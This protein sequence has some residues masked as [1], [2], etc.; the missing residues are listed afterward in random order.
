MSDN[1][2]SSDCQVVLRS[3][4]DSHADL[5]QIEALKNVP[6]FQKMYFKA[7]S[8]STH[9]KLMNSIG[10]DGLNIRFLLKFPKIV[11]IRPWG[12]ER[13]KILFDLAIPGYCDC[14]TVWPS[15][16]I[17]DKDILYFVFGEID[18]RTKLAEIMNRNKRTDLYREI[19]R[20]VDTYMTSIKKAISQVPAK[21]VWISGLHPQPKITE[22]T[23]GY[24]PTT[25]SFEKRWLHTLL[26]N[27]KLKLY[28]EQYGYYFID[29]TEGYS[30]PD[31]DLDM[32][33]TDGNHHLNFWTEKTRNEI[34]QQ[35]ITH[36]NKVC[37]VNEIFLPPQE[38]EI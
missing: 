19:D 20:L 29:L 10:R 14:K 9:A 3:F 38:Y 5:S 11:K 37:S 32:T 25:G 8:Y 13:K 35:L 18:T 31:G 1:L 33:M 22:N 17:T 23:K 27:R 12:K 7:Y 30:T 2:K 28:C 24:S 26:I 15:S 34:A 21:T 4:G 6:P 16:P 36:R